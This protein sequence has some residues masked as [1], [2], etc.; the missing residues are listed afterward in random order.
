MSAPQAQQQ[1]PQQ[2]QYPYHG[3]PPHN[4][5]FPSS[6]YGSYQ[7]A[8]C[9]PSNPYAAHIHPPFHGN[10]SSSTGP[11]PPET[12]ICHSCGQRGVH[13][14]TKCPV[15]ARVRPQ[16]QQQQTHAPRLSLY[17]SSIPRR[18]ESLAQ[19]VQHHSMVM[20]SSAQQGSEARHDRPTRAGRGRGGRGHRGMGRG[21]GG[22]D[23]KERSRWPYGEQ[24]LERTGGGSRGN[25]S[26]PFSTDST[27]ASVPACPGPCSGPTGKESTEAASSV[28]G[29]NVEGEMHR[30][31]ACD[32]SFESQAQYQAHVDAHETC[33][34][35]N[36]HFQGSRQVVG[37]H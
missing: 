32:K 12:Y 30:C 5:S 15:V 37:G 8:Q 34:H 19:D 14:V 26:N 20:A 17:S 13:W 28:G 35:P 27:H 9:P 24:I 3:A 33:Q 4:A 23:G 25:I 22:R 31:Q 18:P 29:T 1:Y 16:E 7:P 2:Y 21:A 11:P 36:C 10:M 6:I